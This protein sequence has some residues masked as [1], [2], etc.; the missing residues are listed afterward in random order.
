MAV[1][2]IPLCFNMWHVELSFLTQSLFSCLTILSFVPRH[3][4]SWIYTS[5]SILT[6]AHS[7]WPLGWRRPHLGPSSSYPHLFQPALYHIIC[8]H[9]SLPCSTMRALEAETS[10]YLPL[11][12]Q[13]HSTAQCAVDAAEVGK[14]IKVLHEVNFHAS[15]GKHTVK[16]TFFWAETTSQISVFHGTQP[17]D[18]SSLGEPNWAAGSFTGPT[19]MICTQTPVLLSSLSLPQP[20]PVFWPEPRALGPP[21]P[22]LASSSPWGGAEWQRELFQD[23]QPR[24]KQS[25]SSCPWWEE[26]GPSRCGREEPHECRAMQEWVRPMSLPLTPCT[27]GLKQHDWWL[28]GPGCLWRAQVMEENCNNH[29]DIGFNISS[30][31]PAYTGRKKLRSTPPLSAPDQVFRSWRVKRLLI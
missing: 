23:P 16:Q 26:A 22:S 13:L 1:R 20:R 9:V 11:S 21:V 5:V 29:F 25:A 27:A 4:I 30:Y 3:S 14:G 12:P 28:P 6:C 19:D 17:W 7:C 15:T 10:P 24:R 18:R 8:L 2:V 31:L